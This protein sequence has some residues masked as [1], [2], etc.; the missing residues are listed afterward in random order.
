MSGLSLGFC[1]LPILS[2]LPPARCMGDGGVEVECRTTRF[3]L[4]RRYLLFAG[5]H[6]GTCYFRRTA[7]PHRGTLAC[8]IP[9]LSPTSDQTRLPAE[10]KHINKRRKRN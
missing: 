4:S 8:E 5:A 7:R 1:S 9:F 2:P 6:G 10:F 3:R